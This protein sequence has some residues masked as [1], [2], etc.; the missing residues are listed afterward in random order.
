MRDTLFR[1]ASIFF[2]RESVVFRDCLLG[3]AANLQP[4]EVGTDCTPLYILGIPPKANVTPND[5][6]QFCSVVFNPYV[7]HDELPYRSILTTKNLILLD[8]TRSMSALHSA[9]GRLSYAWLVNGAL[10]R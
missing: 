5:F 2:T 10:L 8:N 7:H 6:A 3:T 9:T 4:S 1:V